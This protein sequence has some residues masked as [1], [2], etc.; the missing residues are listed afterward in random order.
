[1]DPEVP[2]NLSNSVNTQFC[3]ASI[4]RAVVGVFSTISKE[5]VDFFSISAFFPVIFCPF[6]C[7]FQCTFPTQLPF[8]LSKPLSTAPISALRK[9]MPALQLLI[10]FFLTWFH[11]W[12]KV[13][14]CNW[15]LDRGNG[16]SAVLHLLLPLQLNLRFLSQQQSGPLLPRSVY[17]CIY[18]KIYIHTLT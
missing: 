8:W 18:I 12:G 15:K 13:K 1:V 3:T 2:D 5:R 17:I 4:F 11:D 7:P 10:G 16:V 9:W 6:P 14:W